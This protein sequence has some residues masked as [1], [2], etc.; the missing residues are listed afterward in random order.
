M[1]NFINY[2]FKVEACRCVLRR[3]GD[4]CCLCF[5]DSESDGAVQF[6]VERIFLGD[7]LVM[8]NVSGLVGRNL[9]YRR[10]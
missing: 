10:L 2:F 6:G 5:G 4:F 3:L 9:F 7:N 8:W 1:C